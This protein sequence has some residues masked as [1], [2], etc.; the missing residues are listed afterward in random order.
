MLDWAKHDLDAWLI[1]HRWTRVGRRAVT[2]FL[3]HEALQNAG[4]MAYFAILSI[5]QL[6]VLGVVVLSFFLGEG[7][8]RQFVIDQI[9]GGTPLDRKTATEVID[10]IIESRGGIGLVSLVFLLWGA[11]GLFSALNRGVATAFVAAKPR[12][13]LQ[14]KLIGLALM[15]LTG[16][17]GVV[18]IAIGIVTGIVQQAAGDVLGDVPGGGLALGLI[19]FVV[20]IVLIF[21]AFLAIYWL[22][23]NR[24]VTLRE[25]WPGAVVATILWTLLRVGFTWYATSIARYDSAFG[26]ISAAISLLVFLY[27][28]SVVVL[29]GAEVA[30]ANVLDRELERPVPV[31]ADV[32]PSRPGAA[33]MELASVAAGGQAAEAGPSRRGAPIPRWALAV[34]GAVA[35]VVVRWLS[36]R[37]RRT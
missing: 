21:V 25:V 8:G 12:G 15:A 37:G 32:V 35:G 23:P 2:G 30:R 5:F 20:P 9:V 11:L 17:L 27:F 3:Q 13:F 18:S 31:F 36:S 7:E 4:S 10:G 24:P 28:A 19:G 33:D 1:R 16:L 26:P 14:D 34:G 22:V 6:I 29:L